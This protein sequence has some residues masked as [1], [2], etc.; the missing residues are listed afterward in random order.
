[1][2]T[3]YGINSNSV[4]TLFSSLSGKTNSNHFVGFS[5]DLSYLS[6]YS[7][8]RNGSYRK[9][10]DAYY[11]KYGTNNSESDKTTNTISN[12]S[13]KELKNIKTNTDD[14]NNSSTELLPTGSKSVFTNVDQKNSD[15]TVTNAYDRDKI[16]DK[17]RE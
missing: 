1:M 3:F 7:N 16:S 13:V 15:G 2:A 12:D 9:L 17:I 6:E 8:I 14:L 5:N 11:K 4:N 10:A